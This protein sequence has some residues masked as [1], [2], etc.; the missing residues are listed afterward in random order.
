MNLKK[1]FLW[2]KFLFYKNSEKVIKWHFMFLTY[3]TSVN[4]E[5]NKKIKWKQ[6]FKRHLYICFDFIILKN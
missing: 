5:T 1:C 2:K 4:L 6:K 3:K